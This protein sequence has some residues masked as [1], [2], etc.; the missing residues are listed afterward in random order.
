MEIKNNNSM[1]LSMAAVIGVVLLFIVLLVFL[2]NSPLMKFDGSV[3][4]SNVVAA[5]IVLI[6]GL[7]TAAITIIGVLLKYSIDQQ[8]DRRLEIESKRNAD[9]QID[10]EKR[11]KLEASIRAIQ[12][13]S[14]ENGTL[15]H[16]VQR[17]GALYALTSLGQ[18]ELALSIL[19]QLI[20][21]KKVDSGTVSDIINQSLLCGDESVQDQAMGLL[22]LRTESV[23]TDMELMIPESI[24]GCKQKFPLSV[25]ESIPFFLA[26]VISLR[27]ASQW[28]EN[29]K[30]MSVGSIIACLAI[31]WEE[32]KDGRIRQNAEVLLNHILEIY[33]EIHLV[34]HPRKKI[35]LNELRKVVL[36][37]EA[38]SVKTGMVLE[39]LKKHA[40]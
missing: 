10:A 2:W 23:M 6:G 39:L 37:K 27:T 29:E 7:L 4:S 11:L 8:T 24:M 16:P 36:A 34:F 15:A 19:Y 9:M 32:E 22:S 26:K 12:L 28:K 31:F 21:E 20:D 30:I 38:P 5:M 25:R 18:Y 3:S 40:K 33:G 1:K 17:S 13:F 14:N 35:D